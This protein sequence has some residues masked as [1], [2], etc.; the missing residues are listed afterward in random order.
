[1]LPG[2][3]RTAAQP[4]SIAANTYLGWKW[5]SAITGICDLRAIAGSASASS[6]LGQATRTM[7][8]PEAVSSAICWRVALT[9]AVRVVVIDCTE[10]G[11]SEPT[12]TAPTCSCRVGRRGANGAAG[13]AGM[14]R[15]TLTTSSIRVFATGGAR[16]G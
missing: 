15:E 10:I 9:S 14:P 13:G 6:W 8:Q 2:L 3:T 16:Q 12:P 7:S 1:M 5:M 11:Y 4:A